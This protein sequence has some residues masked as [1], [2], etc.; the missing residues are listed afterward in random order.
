MDSSLFKVLVSAMIFGFCGGFCI[1]RAWVP[2]VF[3]GFL[4]A[5]LNSI[6]WHLL[7]N[8]CFYQ[9]SKTGIAQWARITV[10]W[11]TLCSLVPSWMGTIFGTTLR[12]HILKNVHN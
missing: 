6:L 4:L 5:F 12:F 3:A 2:I 11:L 8:Y 9:E 7:D 1:R 10:P